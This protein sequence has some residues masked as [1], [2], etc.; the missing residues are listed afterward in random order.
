MGAVAINAIDYDEWSIE[1][2]IENVAANNC[3]KISLIKAE[4]ITIGKVYDIIL[5]N[6]NLHVILNNLAAIKATAKKGT[7]ILLSGFIKADEE[8]MINA[9]T[10]NGIRVH[11]TSQKGEWICILAEII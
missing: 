1:N 11:N 3:T 2:S 6:I 9:L 7:V 5:A 4:T 10:A 8:I